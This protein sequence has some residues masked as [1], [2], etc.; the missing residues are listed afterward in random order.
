MSY[1]HGVYIFEQPTSILPPARVDAA[2]PFVVGSAPIF[3]AGAPAPVNEP[4]LIYN[5]SEA[6]AYFGFDREDN[7]ADYTLSEFMDAY[8][9]LF[10]VSPMVVVNVFDPATHKTSVA[11]EAK[12]FNSKGEVTAAHRGILTGTLLVK[13]TD[14]STTYVAGTDYTADLATGVVSRKSTGAITAGQAIKLTYDYADPSKVTKAD[15]IGG[16]DG[17]TGAVTGLELVNQVFPRFRIV[18]GQI[19]APKWSTDPEVAALMVAKAGNINSHFKAIA[20]VDVPTTGTD[21]VTLYSNVPGYKE[22]NNLTDEQLVVCWPKVKL[23]SKEYHLSSQMAGIMGQVDNDNESVPYHSPSNKRLQ[24]VA[25]VADGSE[26]F[27]GPDQATYLNSQGIVTA[28]NFIGGWR[29]WGNRTGA[30]PGVTDPKDSFIAIRR[31]FNWIGNTLVLTFWQKVDFPV[32]RRL[33]ETI[34]DSS[35]IW[36][37]GL[38]ARQFILGGRVEFNRDENPVTDLMDGIIKFHV[39]VTPPSPAREI[40]FILEYDPAYL[41]TLFG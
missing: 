39:Y 41:E 33:I 29:S 2:I 18:P 10:N 8:F 37:N 6:A 28:L 16:V 38:S 13:N 25:A 36:L 40:D 4:R 35:N 34:L 17:V 3:A 32:N 20:V 19:H 14:G 9:G 22:T 23:G 5:A 12:T 27:L 7:F 24:A 31:M 30:Y 1:R 26:V 11:S 21:K 15:I